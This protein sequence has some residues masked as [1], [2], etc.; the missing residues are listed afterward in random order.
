M[1]IKEQNQKAQKL[2]SYSTSLPTW[3]KFSHSSFKKISENSNEALTSMFIIPGQPNKESTK[4]LYRSS[5]GTMW[6]QRKLLII[7]IALQTTQ[8]SKP[9]L[10]WESMSNLNTSKFSTVISNRKKLIP[11]CKAQLSKQNSWRSLSWLQPKHK[12][13]KNMTI[14]SKLSDYHQALNVCNRNKQ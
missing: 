2:I 12:A 9:T 8:D 10:P 7:F 11:F 5:S 14:H 13:K 4:S 6:T 1:D 3:K